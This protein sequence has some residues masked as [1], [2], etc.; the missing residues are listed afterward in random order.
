MPW[1]RCP[2]P[3]QPRRLR[4]GLRLAI[5]VQSDLVAV[6][7]LD[8]LVALAAGNDD[9]LAR[10]RRPELLGQVHRDR[11]LVAF[12]FHIHVL[13][14]ES[15]LAGPIIERPPT[16]CKRLTVRALLR[17][18]PHARR[19][20]NKGLRSRPTIVSPQRKLW[21]A[22]SRGTRGAERRHNAR[23]CRRSAARC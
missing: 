14:F 17:C 7:V 18:L 21:V 5:D 20:L 11:K 13:H 23:L 12:H 3:V 4:Y 6:F 1:A 10:R 9:G 8:G 2:R 15:S 22:M 19:N 16:D